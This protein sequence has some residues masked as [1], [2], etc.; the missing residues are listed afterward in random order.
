MSIS[1]TSN[2]ETCDLCQFHYDSR[3]RAPMI[4]CKSQHLC[5]QTCVDLYLSKE[6]S[7]CNTCKD[8][9]SNPTVFRLYPNYEVKKEE[10]K[11]KGLQELDKTKES[12]LPIM[13]GLIDIHKK[14]GKIQ[15]LITLLKNLSLKCAQNEQ[16]AQGYTLLKELI[17]L[18]PIAA[19]DQSFIGL[20]CNASILAFSEE[21]G[22]D[23]YANRTEEKML[24]LLDQLAFC[25]QK[26]GN[27]KKAADYYHQVRGSNA[28]YAKDYRIAFGA[29]VS[30]HNLG[31]T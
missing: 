2:V 30:E 8:P 12:L 27:F 3:V 13:V 28:E 5:C 9:I 18:D 31:N 21:E 25:F 19:F 23:W 29:A 10:K 6:G 14:G 1:S 20:G 24:S 7:C 26:E 16:Y 4:I 15:Q 22:F 11:Q 17:A